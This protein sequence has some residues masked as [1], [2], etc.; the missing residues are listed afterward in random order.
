[1]ES[2]VFSLPALGRAI[3]AR[4]SKAMQGFYSQTARLRIIDC[5][6]PPSRPLEIVGHDAIAA[7][8]DDVCGRMM[9]H[10]L[11]NA[12]VNR[13]R[14]AFTQ[15]CAYPDGT[16]VFCSAMAE[17]KDAKI[18]NQTVVQAWDA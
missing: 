7:Y 17:L 18:T 5:D 8:F 15:S 2:D 11:E 12:C 4:D 10:R 6:H 14:L 16:R 3:E 1:M 9:T 13:E